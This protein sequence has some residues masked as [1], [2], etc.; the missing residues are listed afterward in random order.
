MNRLL[1]YLAL[2]SLV[3][4]SLLSAKLVFEEQS[5]SY[6]ADI[7]QEKTLATFKFTNKGREVVRILD[8]KAGCGCTVPELAK[9]V[10]KP[11]ERGK[12]HVTF[13]HD[14]RQGQIDN[15]ITVTTDEPGNNRYILGLNV[16]IP[17]LLSIQPRLLFWKRS[18]SLEPKDFVIETLE[19]IESMAINVSNNEAFML[20]TKRL[21]PRRKYAVT[22]TPLTDSASQQARVSV[23]VEFRDGSERTTN[24]FLRVQ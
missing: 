20:T 1:R 11:G 15:G 5:L 13:T 19:D 23:D 8:M 21:V 17:R 16:H 3:L 7:G 4:P 18:E 9:T 12:I 6:T 22:V 10:F 14:G 24:A 2:C